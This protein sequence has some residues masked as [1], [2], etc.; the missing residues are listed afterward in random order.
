MWCLMS[1]RSL[2]SKLREG[3]GCLLLTALPEAATGGV[4]W[5]AEVSPGELKRLVLSFSESH[6]KCL[7]ICGRIWYWLSDLVSKEAYS[8]PL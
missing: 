4:L 5:Q 8:Q 7:G 1:L 2:N 6:S 3:C